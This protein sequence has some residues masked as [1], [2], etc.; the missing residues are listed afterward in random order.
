MKKICALFCVVLLLFSVGC[1][2]K[3][4][5]KDHIH[6]DEY[7]TLNLKINPDVSFIVDENDQV[8]GIV[9]NNED[10]R[11]VYNNI[12]FSNYDLNTVVNE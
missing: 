12:S 10:A 11:D 9:T 3:K 4:E 6:N 8:I 1:S 7:F 5:Q 2:S